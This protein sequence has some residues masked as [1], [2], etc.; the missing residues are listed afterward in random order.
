[1]PPFWEGK[2]TED[3]GCYVVLPSSVRLALSVEHQ[4]GL[5]FEP[6]GTLGAVPLAKTG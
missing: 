5:A 6:F 3:M 1:M 2:S 4:T